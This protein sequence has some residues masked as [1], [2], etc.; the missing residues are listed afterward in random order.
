MKKVLSESGEPP[1]RI[2][3][4][5]EVFAMKV[6]DF[7]NSLKNSE[8][9]ANKIKVFK[10]KLVY[11]SLKASLQSC[12]VCAADLNFHVEKTLGGQRI[13]EITHCL[14]CKGAAVQRFY[15]LN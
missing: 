6:Q 1:K 5:Q 10:A 4:G 2:L 12:A 7:R 9:I 15:S 11:E 13:K 14:S 3:S 8:E